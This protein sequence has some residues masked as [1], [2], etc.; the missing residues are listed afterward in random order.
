MRGRGQGGDKEGGTP[1]AILFARLIGF[2][3]H[4]PAREA[5]LSEIVWGLVP[6]ELAPDLVLKC[7]LHYTVGDP[8]AD[9]SPLKNWQGIAPLEQWWQETERLCSEIDPGQ[10]ETEFVRTWLLFRRALL[11]RALKNVEQEL[12]LAE[13]GKSA[14]EV[15]ELVIRF[16]E[17]SEALQELSE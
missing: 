6:E 3:L 9:A 7:K 8:V 10:I 15:K 16:Q 12:A 13:M 4:D 1:L 5:K 17:L 2:V 14:A 11:K